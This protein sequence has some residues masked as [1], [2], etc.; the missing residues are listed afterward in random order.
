VAH[1][2]TRVLRWCTSVTPSHR[3]T[4][5]PGCGDVVELLLA[6]GAD[7]SLPVDGGATP[8]HAA[9]ANGSLSTVLA[10]LQVRWPLAR[11]SPGVLNVDAAAFED[12]HNPYSGCVR[13]DVHDWLARPLNRPLQASPSN[14]TTTCDAHGSQAVPCL[15]AR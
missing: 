2:P 7:P 10:L 6:A 5:W 1:S 11:R 14:L 13:R 9:A 3:C 4:A 15:S 12:H 8:L